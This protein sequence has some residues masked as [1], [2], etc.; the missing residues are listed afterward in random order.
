MELVIPVVVL[1]ATLV[2]MAV[3]VV[4]GGFPIEDAVYDVVV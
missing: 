4:S 1:I 3:I 2:V